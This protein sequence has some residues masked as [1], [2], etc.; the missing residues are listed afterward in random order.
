[1]IIINPY[2]FVAATTVDPY[3]ANVE[4]LLHMNGTNGSTS[5]IDSSIIQHSVIAFGAAKVMTASAKFGTGGLL[6]GGLGDYITAP[7]NAAFAFG[8]GDFTVE[9]WIKTSDSGESV[10]IDQFSSGSTFSSWQLSVKSG[11]LSWYRRLVGGSS[12]Y[13]LTGS[14]TISDNAWHH[15]AVTRASNTLRFFVDGVANGSVTDSADYA[16]SVVTLGI[17]A[18]VYSRNSAYDLAA[19]LDDIRITKGVARYTAAF[20]P[21]TEAFPNT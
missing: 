15:I 14:T 17:G 13:L 12:S 4:L 10:I 11:V 2:Q 3:F 7:A 20:A 21:P 19:S 16:T 9:F 6:I 18:Q 5:F 8:T 1:M